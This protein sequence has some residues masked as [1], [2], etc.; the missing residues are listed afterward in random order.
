MKLRVF[1]IFERKLMN[2]TCPAIRQRLEITILG[3][4]RDRNFT[5]L[6]KLTEESQRQ[7]PRDYD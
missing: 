3:F 2:E 4:F 1:A 7:G 5:L 6:W